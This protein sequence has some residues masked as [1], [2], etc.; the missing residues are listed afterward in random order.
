MSNKR[1]DKEIHNIGYSIKD[2][3]SFSADYAKLN[4]D[5]EDTVSRTIFGII[6]IPIDALINKITPEMKTNE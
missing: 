6:H 1:I 4:C 5:V 2:F 3:K